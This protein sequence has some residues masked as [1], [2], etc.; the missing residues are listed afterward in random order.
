MLPILR[1]YALTIADTELTDV[2]R[3]AHAATNPDDIE[4]RTTSGGSRPFLGPRQRGHKVP[5]LDANPRQAQDRGQA[6]V[7][8]A[9][10]EHFTGRQ[11]PRTDKGLYVSYAPQNSLGIHDATKDANTETTK[12]IPN[13]AR[14]FSARR[15]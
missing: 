2:E 3:N 9:G 7:P 14:N 1:H 12:P 4:L 8:R 15:A 10:H 5:D 6:S 11:R 13:S